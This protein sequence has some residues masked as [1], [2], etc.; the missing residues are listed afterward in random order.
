MTDIKL[1][2][3]LNEYYD[4]QQAVVCSMIWAMQD[5]QRGRED[6]SWAHLFDWCEHKDRTGKLR[7]Q[8]EGDY[9]RAIMLK[10]GCAV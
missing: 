1:L 3:L 5:F 10:E 8:F 2:T 4:E 7:N 6:D 9:P